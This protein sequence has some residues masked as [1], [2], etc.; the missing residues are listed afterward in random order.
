MA[1]QCSHSNISE[2]S[3]E[4]KL[5]NNED[6][7]SDKYYLIY[8]PRQYSDHQLERVN[9]WVEIGKPTYHTNVYLVYHYE[10][11]A[12]EVLKHVVIGAL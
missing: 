3:I 2:G 4:V 11:D 7:D 10:L 9:P 6:I 8:L 1:S 5:A 12:E